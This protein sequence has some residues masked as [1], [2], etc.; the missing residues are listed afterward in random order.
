MPNSAALQ[1]QKSQ[2][3]NNRVYAFVRAKRNVVENLTP[4]LLLQ[5]SPFR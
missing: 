5:L 3:N 4:K 2:S 1:L